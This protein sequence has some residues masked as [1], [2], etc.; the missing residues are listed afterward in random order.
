MVE[1][2]LMAALA[3]VMLD[4]LV[5]WSFDAELYENGLWVT[6]AA[7][8]VYLLCGGCRQLGWQIIRSTAESEKGTRP[9]QFSAR[10]LMI[11][12]AATGV[13][14]V[15]AQRIGEAVQ[16]GGGSDWGQRI[17]MGLLT[18]MG[19]LVAV[20]ALLGVG[21]IAWKAVLAFIVM[22]LLALVVVAVVGEWEL[23]V[24]LLVSGWS[25]AFFLFVSGLL[26]GVR[27]CRFRV[28]LETKASSV[29]R[30]PMVS[31]KV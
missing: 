4:L 5:A 3:T 13:M 25:C 28:S 16:N 14:I 15:I 2:C 22:Q 21:R 6:P 19:F 29:N 11:V 10:H 9:P 27:S 23:D 18:S 20:W 24:V 7:V 1:R 26:L 30:H 12:T 8:C 17:G 31:A